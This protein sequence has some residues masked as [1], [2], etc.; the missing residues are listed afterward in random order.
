VTNAPLVSICIPTYLGA[1]TIGATIESVLGQDFQDFELIIVDDGSPDETGAIV[2]R[3]ADS[4]IRY[5]R[6][7]RNLGPLGNWNRCQA[8]AQ[9]KY[10]KLLPHDDLLA[11]SCL[12]QQVKVLENDTEERIALVFCA[13]DVIG[14]DGRVLTH[15]GYPAREGI[16]PGKLLARR[17]VR[18]GTN[19]IGE[20][21]GVLF[22]RSLA[23]VV[24]CFDATN[25]YVIDLDYWFRLLAHGDAYYLPQH[26][27]SFRVSGQ[28]WSVRLGDS[29]ANDFNA[30]VARIGPAIGLEWT[31]GDKLMSKM[32][33]RL[34]NWMRL[35]FYL[36]FLR[37]L[38][39]L[40]RF[41]KN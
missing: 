14:P 39:N 19:L 3:F 23:T 22:R 29:Q 28:Q 36:V 33:S 25:S 15:R 16:I 6:N 30:F 8:L 9:G 10:F 26:L 1:Q 27:S 40:Q 32:T 18:A 4:R 37:L 34:N 21:G 13:R 17:S 31:F 2:A 38:P 12:T 24:G 5:E 11:P 41:R 7:E 35:G 20:P